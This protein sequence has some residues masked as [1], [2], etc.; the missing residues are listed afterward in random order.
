[1]LRFCIPAGAALHSGLDFCSVMARASLAFFPG[2]RETG[3]PVR[4]FWGTGTV[5]RMTTVVVGSLGRGGFAGDRLRRSCFAG[6]GIQGGAY[7]VSEPG[8]GR[9]E[10]G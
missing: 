6:G 9:G 2:R 1:M 3:Y 5:S 7:G 10:G 8:R 4:V